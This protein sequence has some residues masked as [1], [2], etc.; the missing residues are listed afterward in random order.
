M[1]K[2]A[3]ASLIPTAWDRRVARSALAGALVM[4]LLALLVTAVTDE[5]GVPWAERASRASA[6]LPLC[7]AVAAALALR[8]R[9]TRGELLALSSLGVGPARRELPAIVGALGVCAVA[10]L[11]VA[12]SPAF[13]PSAFFPAERAPVTFVREAGAFVAEG[14]VRI[15]DDGRI[16]RPNAPVPPPSPAAAHGVRAEG[17]RGM[18]AAVLMLL[19]AALA[20]LGARGSL[21]AR[22]VV[23]VVAASGAEI[24]TFHLVA[25][26]RA[27]L[28][29]CLVVPALLLGLAARVFLAPRQGA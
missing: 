5:G 21:R 2:L 6:A 10:A 8:G 9:R 28:W 1:S 14:G 17:R 18:V 15:T 29:S 16:L 26:G 12:M 24:L 19:G 23:L 27:P 7:V 11:A 13:V 3:G 25:A 4:T 22:E 20:V